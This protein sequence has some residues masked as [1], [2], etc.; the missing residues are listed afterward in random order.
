MNKVQLIGRLT[1]DVE[2]IETKSATKVVKFSLAVRR[3]NKDEVD[4][5]NMVA[6]GNSAEFIPKYFSKGSQIAVSG[7]LQVKNYEDKEGNKR[8]ATDV[9]VE[10]VYFTESKKDKDDKD[11]PF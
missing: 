7:R 3:R 5:I 2:V 11:L 10:E 8:T 1:R 4:F 9:V 6:F